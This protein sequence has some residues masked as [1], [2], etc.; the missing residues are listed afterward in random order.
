M[1]LKSNPALWVAILVIV[2]C[3]GV[4]EAQTVPLPVWNVTYDTYTAL[5]IGEDRVVVCTSHCDIDLG[6]NYLSIHPGAYARIYDVRT[7]A[8]LK[9]LSGGS[10]GVTYRLS[11]YSAVWN[12]IVFFSGNARFG[13]E[14]PQRYGTSAR[15]V[16]LMT[17]LTRPIDFTG[18]A[19]G[20]YYYP[21]QMDYYGNYLVIGEGN[22]YTQ[23]RILLYKFNGTGYQL[24]WN[25]TVIGDVRRVFMTLDARYIVYGALAHPY[26][27]IA[28]NQNDNVRVIAQIP[29]AG[30]V[31]ALSATNLYNVGYILVGT[32]NGHVYVFDASKSKTSPSLVIH[33]NNSTY[34]Q[35]TGTTGR[36][37]NPF[38]NRYNP[39]ENIRMVAFSTVTSPYVTILV[40]L[41]TKQFYRYSASGYGRATAISLQG[42]YLFGGRTLFT[43]ANPDIQKGEPRVR[44]TGTTYFNYAEMP[45]DLSRSILLQ[46]PEEKDYHGYFTGGSIKVTGLIAER[47]SVELVRDQ[48]ILEGKLG[49]M[50]NRGLIRPEV[51]V[52][53]GGTVDNPTIKYDSENQITYSATH[54]HTQSYLGW[55]GTWFGLQSGSVV[56]SGVAIRVPLDAEVSPFEEVQFIPKI[57]VASATA[58]YDVWGNLLGVSGI[59]IVTGGLSATVGK[60]ALSKA[61]SRLG[62]PDEVMVTETLHSGAYTAGRVASRVIGVAG[63]FLIVDG[64]I[65]LATGYMGYQ[66]MKTGILY[67]PIIEDTSTGSKYAV[68]ALILPE[69]EDTR[70]YEKYIK[71]YMNKFGIR[72]VGIS[73]YRWGSSWDDYRNK[74]SKEQI[75]QI[76]Y[77]SEI[78]AFAVG[79]GL[80]PKNLRIKEVVVVVSTFTSAYSSLFD[81]LF[82]GLKIPVGFSALG[83][84]ISVSATTRAFSTTDP[85]QIVTLIP[86]VV[87]NGVEYPLS[88]SPEGAIAQFMLPL[89]ISQLAISFPNAPYSATLVIGANTI[90]KSPFKLVKTGIYEAK[91]HYNLSINNRDVLIRVDKIELLDMP[92]PRTKIEREFIYA[93]GSFVHDV[94]SAFEL[95]GT[96]GGRYYYSTIK[97]TKFLDP[98]NG[99]TMQPCKTY[100]FRYYT[101]EVPSGNAWVK[102]YFNGTLPTSTIPRQGTVVLGSQGV[103]QTVKAN[104]Q[105]ATV[106]ETIVSGY[107][108]YDYVMSQNYTITKSIPKNGNVTVEYDIQSFVAKAIELVKQN[109]T[110]FVVVSAEITSAEYNDY[111]SDDRDKIVWYPPPSVIPPDTPVALSVK[112]VDA[113]T[114]SALQGVSVTLKDMNGNVVESKTTDSAG[115]ANFSVYPAGYY[116]V[117]EKTGYKQFNSSVNVYTNMTYTVQLVPESYMPPEEGKNVTLSVFV[118]DYDGYAI[119]TANVTVNGVSKLTNAQ[120]WANF[121]VRTGYVTV[122]VTKDG[123]YPFE[124]TIYV[125]DNMTFRVQLVPISFNLLQYANLTVKVEYSD[126]MPVSGVSISVKNTTSG[127]VYLTG[128]T[129]STGAFRSVIPKGHQITINATKNSWNASQ[130]VTMDTD[131]YILFTIP[132][133]SPEPTYSRVSVVVQYT[134]GAP[135]EGATVTILDNVTQTTIS[136]LTT[137]GTG[138]AK[139]LVPRDKLIDITASLA[140]KTIVPD[141]YR[142][143][144]T[145]FTERIFVFLV[146]ETSPIYQPEVAIYNLSLVV[147]RGQGYY[148]GNISHLVVAEIY[149]TENQ[150]ITLYLR[151]FETGTN[152][153]H[154]SK[155]VTLNVMR[156]L[157]VY[158][159]WLEVNVTGNFTE[160]MAYAKI[161]SYQKDTNV[162]NNERYSNP[163]IIKPYID[164]YPS[165]MWR[166]IKQ[167]VPYALLPDDIIEISICYY[168]PVALKDIEFKHSISAFAIKEKTFKLLEGYETKADALAGALCRNYTI[169]VPFTNKIIVNASVSHPFEDNG[170]NDRLSVE[171]EVM[172]NTAITR[173]E[174]P[175]LV[176]A[177]VPTTVKVHIKSNNYGRTISAYVSDLQMNHTLLGSV[178]NVNVTD[179]EM[180]IEVPVV[181][182]VGMANQFYSTRTWEISVA[183]YDMYPDDDIV[184]VN[185]TVWNLPWWLWL[186]L[187]LI[188]VLFV[189]A[190]IKSLLFTIRRVGGDYRFYRRRSDGFAGSERNAGKV[191]EVDTTGFRFYRRRSP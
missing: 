173:V 166:I 36:F 62:V 26:L 47:R 4:A 52:A 75:P 153:T 63:V 145:N 14:N 7:G 169:P 50:Y 167:K 130:T 27:Y 139:F 94:T 18:T 105:I 119:S 42:N 13:I 29:L 135:V 3:L 83:Q 185:V 148:F 17:M 178:K 125:W 159:D 101:T 179:E 134:D 170:W 21:T 156:G 184:T 8:L 84:G 100:V 69:G 131:K 171:I 35:G 150:Q 114:L 89:G 176:R 102:V 118:Y 28:E 88:P 59:E 99:A 137:D 23:G 34:P 93:Y 19:G 81:L 133:P 45:I 189:I 79:K 151:I 31:G 22:G 180:V 109:A 177:D 53:Y 120:G 10:D 111:I 143:I 60:T 90:I 106:K 123:F 97:N 172:P 66:S 149:S 155:T 164:L 80:E 128:F 182:K 121:T 74:L 168:I 154:S 144:Y 44:F 68:V 54:R 9:E 96:S 187:I 104:V 157:N 37:Y 48:D 32:D 61:V 91:F 181:P 186:V 190:I 49:K 73:V 110:A 76:N 67:F 33:I 43:L 127:S 103:S 163:V 51:I 65:G 126:G 82:G 158:M 87:V 107:P 55:L 95:T 141:S 165:I 124:Q 116:V 64:V 147:H 132:A 117:A 183:G 16:D 174:T 70:A 85:N 92:A 142:G 86:Q 58:H 113:I 25:S 175:L 146:N 188:I 77:I 78:T 136:Q 56:E 115:F 1:Y 152:K 40:D 6:Y 72:D 57:A 160:M 122:N 41:E 12:R 39:P 20:T 140:G 161:T 138:Y 129:D 108:K 15:V 98:A 162:S 24:I 30:G 71:D 11:D 5:F 191:D 46:I 38:Y 112:V 2:A